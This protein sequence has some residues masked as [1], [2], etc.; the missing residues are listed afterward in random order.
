MEYN[1]AYFIEN[2]PK[3]PKRSPATYLGYRISSF[4]LQVKSIGKEVRV[5]IQGA[6]LFYEDE[7]YGE[8]NCSMYS[9]R[10]GAPS[11]RSCAPFAPL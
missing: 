6:L 9:E 2:K 11:A 10:A 1:I 8:V 4:G 7:L 5:E 3:N